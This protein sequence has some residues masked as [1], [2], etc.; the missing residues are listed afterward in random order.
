MQTAASLIPLTGPGLVNIAH[1]QKFLFFRA[2]EQNCTVFSGSPAA[3][4][5]LVRT[6]A[7]PLTHP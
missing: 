7:G 6:E 1:L 4:F 2:C 3:H 5:R